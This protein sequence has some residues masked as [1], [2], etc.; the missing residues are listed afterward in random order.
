MANNA[1]LAPIVMDIRKMREGLDPER[2]DELHD[3]FVSL[4]DPR[5]AKYSG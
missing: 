2:T 1:V 3:V 4:L 5:L